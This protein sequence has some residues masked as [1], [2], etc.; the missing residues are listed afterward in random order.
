MIFQLRRFPLRSVDPAHPER[1]YRS[2]PVIPLLVI[3]QSGRIQHHPTVD[4][5][6]VTSLF[7][8]EDARRLGI[9]D[10][11]STGQLFGVG[12][13]RATP[14]IVRYAEVVLRV[15]DQ[16][17]VCQW[18]AIVG[19]TSAVMSSDGLFGMSGGIEYFHTSIDQFADQLTMI[20]RVTLP[21][22]AET[23]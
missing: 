18:K 7:P 4:T 6:A 9:R 8:I 17:E 3:G 14:L 23:L 11:H 1:R 21:V 15:W 22:V 2:R 16:H 20:P 10:F 12:S 5:G 13:S 19:F